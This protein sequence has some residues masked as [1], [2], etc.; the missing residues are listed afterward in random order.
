VAASPF[1]GGQ[2]VTATAAGLGKVQG[3]RTALGKGGTATYAKG[4]PWW[5]SYSKGNSIKA[6]L[7]SFKR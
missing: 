3:N 5:V 1:S 6:K 2:T 7:V 4:V